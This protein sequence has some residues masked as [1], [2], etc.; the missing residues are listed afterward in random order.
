MPL[1]KTRA[2]AIIRE[3]GYKDNNFMTRVFVGA[4][5]TENSWASRLDIPIMFLLKK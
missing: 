1:I 3:S 5:H 4:N 2:K